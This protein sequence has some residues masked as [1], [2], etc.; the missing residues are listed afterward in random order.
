MPTATSIAIE[1]VRKEATAALEGVRKETSA[2]MEVVQKE[3]SVRQIQFDCM[4]AELAELDSMKAELAKFDS[5]KAE[6]AKFDC[7]KAELAIS[8]KNLQD[9]QQRVSVRSLLRDWSA[10]PASKQLNQKIVKLVNRKYA[11]A[12]AAPLYLQHRR[13]MDNNLQREV[14]CLLTDVEEHVNE[15]RA[16]KYL[17]LVESAITEV[18]KIPGSEYLSLLEECLQANNLVH[19]SWTK[20]K[21]REVL[22]AIHAGALNH[23]QHIALWILREFSIRKRWDV[24]VTEEDFKVD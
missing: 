16:K 19:V 15:E 5:V 9:L 1:T 13:C 17:A 2:A 22:F 21:L 24:G 6:L 3:A 4:K 8:K 10:T 12:R 7:M 18:T 20:E 11:A 14:R 23:G